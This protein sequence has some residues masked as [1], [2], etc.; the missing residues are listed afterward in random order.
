MWCSCRRGGMR[1]HGSGGDVELPRAGHGLDCQPGH[2][3]RS[4]RTLR[5]QVGVSGRCGSAVIP[6]SHFG[7]RFDKR[8]RRRGD[9]G[10]GGRNAQGKCL[11]LG[12]MEHGGRGEAYQ[13]VQ[14]PP[15]ARMLSGISGTIARTGWSRLDEPQGYLTRAAAP[16]ATVCMTATED[17]P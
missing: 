10:G 8:D 15:Q 13:G 17:R 4:T 3:G 12:R 14:R 9:G 16:T 7:G 2:C 11:L 1:T 6:T 5:G